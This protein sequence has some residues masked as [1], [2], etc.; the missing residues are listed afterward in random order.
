MMLNHSL[1][2]TLG[3][4]TQVLALLDRQVNDKGGHD[5]HDQI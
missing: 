3:R 2:A 1:R 4:N 5:V